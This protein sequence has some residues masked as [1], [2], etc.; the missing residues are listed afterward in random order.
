MTLTDARQ[1]VEAQPDPAMATRR[2]A[3]AERVARQREQQDRL[4]GLVFTPESIPANHLV[5]LFVDMC[6]TGNLIVCEARAV[7]QSCPRSSVD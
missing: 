4:G 2:M 5:D 3:T 1:R 6:E 7:L